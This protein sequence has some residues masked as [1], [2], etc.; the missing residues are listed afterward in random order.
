VRHARNIYSCEIASLKFFCGCKNFYRQKCFI[1][2]LRKSK[3][4]QGYESCAAAPH[5]D[6]HALAQA[7]GDLGV[8]TSRGNA[9]GVQAVQWALPG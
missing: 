1:G 6:P 8:V 7:R 9:G 4:E 5:L 3:R 2:T